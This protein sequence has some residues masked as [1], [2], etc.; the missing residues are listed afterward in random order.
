MKLNIFSYRYALEILQHPS[1]AP[2]WEEIETILSG[3][4][5]FIYPGKS[6]NN[7][8]LLVVQQLLNT[9]FD[10]RFAVDCGWDHHP[11]ATGIPSSNLAADFRK[12]FSGLSIQ[13]EIQFG[14]MARWYSDIFKF[15][16]AYSK[17]LIQCGLSVVPM[18]S[19][20]KL[21]DSNI[22]NFERARREL[23]SAELS[24]TLPI[25]LVGLEPDSTTPQVEVS[26]CAFAN[27][28]QI[29]GQGKHENRWRIVNGYLNN[30]PMS[31]IGPASETGPMIAD[32]SGD[33]DYDP[34]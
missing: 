18:S 29:T 31:S 12:T 14:N 33:H 13:A 10:R 28:K 5:L 34:D 32:S 27:V 17:S 7:P 15:Q 23:P 30:V 21:I 2:A 24:I 26:S 4:P 6:G 3:A 11:L 22:V 25:L 9:Y 1:H 20:A 8:N 16:A 19:V